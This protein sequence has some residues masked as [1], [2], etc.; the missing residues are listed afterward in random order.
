MT[1]QPPKVPLRRFGDRS[2]SRKKITA[3]KPPPPPPPLP[4][5]KKN[6]SMKTYMYKGKPGFGGSERT[7]FYIHYNPFLKNIEQVKKF[8]QNKD[9][10]SLMNPVLNTNRSL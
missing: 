1:Q 6:E 8:A 9:Q 10:Y 5:K 2:P 3:A 4:M 7:E